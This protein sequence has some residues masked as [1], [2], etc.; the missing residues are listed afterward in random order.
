MEEGVEE[1]WLSGAMEEMDSM[2]VQKITR[3]RGKEENRKW[4]RLVEADPSTVH[5]HLQPR[6]IN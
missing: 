1:R 6:Q 5:D 3:G 4:G 2:A